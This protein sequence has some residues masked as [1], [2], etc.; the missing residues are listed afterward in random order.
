MG[1]WDSTSQAPAGATRAGG[2]TL[3]ALG[4]ALGHATRVTCIVLTVLAMHSTGSDAATLMAPPPCAPTLNLSALSHGPVTCSCSSEAANSGVV[5]GEDNY[6]E[7]S[8]TCRAALH[9]G[10]IA[11][12]GGVVTI[13]QGVATP[14]YPGTAR[15]GVMSDSWGRGASSF[16]FASPGELLPELVAASAA[17]CP[18]TLPPDL[19]VAYLS[20]TCPATSGQ[21]GGDVWGTTVYTTDSSLCAAARHAGAVG[22]A[23]GLVTLLTLPGL[24]TYRGSLRNGVTS[25]DASQWHSS[26]R[27]LAT[28]APGP[29]LCHAPTLAA[30]GD[31][32]AGCWQP[33]GLPLRVRTRE[34]N[35]RTEDAATCLPPCVP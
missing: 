33:S 13:L 23:G 16:R 17:R 10:V 34:R 29:N 9:A 30:G 24:E 4:G 6:M 19:E 8:A 18:T 25:R 3:P 31:G 7:G 28:A 35:T 32:V 22:P 14:V 27:F 12:D 2:A 11:T 15:N 5:W 21:L 26:F 20:C 1:S